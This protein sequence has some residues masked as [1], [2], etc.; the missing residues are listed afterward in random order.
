MPHL[1]RPPRIRF[2]GLGAKLHNL[3]AQG[4]RLLIKGTSRKLIDRFEEGSDKGLKITER[5]SIV[6]EKNAFDLDSREY[7]QVL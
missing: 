7:L 5:E 6:T 4:Q 3:K 2:P 1:R